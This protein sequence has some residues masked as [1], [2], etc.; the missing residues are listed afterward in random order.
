MSCNA[1]L[2][3]LRKLHR[4]RHKPDLHSF[5]AKIYNGVVYV[6]AEWSGIFI[7]FFTC[8]GEG[9]ETRESWAGTIEAAA[10]E[11]DRRCLDMATVET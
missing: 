7:E 5:K 11:L 8:D 9:K 2:K 6:E 4:N 3:L 1:I 10:R